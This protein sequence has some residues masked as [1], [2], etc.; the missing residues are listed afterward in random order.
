MEV[1]WN[2]CRTMMIKNINPFGSSNPDYFFLHNGICYFNADD[3]T[4]W[5][6]LWRT[7]G[8]EAGTYMVK[9]INTSTGGSYPNILLILPL[10]LLFFYF[11]A[12]AG[13]VWC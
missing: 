7:D 11:A 2:N 3:G 12:V 4:H 13:Y 8:T 10:I 6:Q 5:N 1:G 9:E